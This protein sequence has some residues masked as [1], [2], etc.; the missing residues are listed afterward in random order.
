M[1]TS[2]M[3]F[4]YPVTVRM[5]DVGPN[6]LVPLHMLLRYFQEAASLHAEQLH[7]GA[8]DLKSENLTWVLSRLFLEVDSFPGP[9]EDF[10]IRTWPSERDKYN[11]KRDFN[12]LDANGVSLGR[13][14][15]N[16]V[17]MDISARRMCAIPS[18]FNVHSHGTPGRILEFSG[19]R[20]P[21]LKVSEHEIQVLAR[22]E[23][24]DLNGHVN[25]THFAAWVLEAVLE[26]YSQ[27]NRLASMDIQF[28]AEVRRGD[29]VRSLVGSDDTGGLLHSLVRES[30]NVEVARARTT[31]TTT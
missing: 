1:Q 19:R 16:W 7:W 14:T 5:H 28:R 18:S 20:V 10:T 23:D 22:Q 11:A 27:A 2:E 12:L 29:A 26:S 13:G 25:N 24:L 30:D 15:S 3:L 17:M 21:A 6:A 4:D 9:W 31:W 8:D